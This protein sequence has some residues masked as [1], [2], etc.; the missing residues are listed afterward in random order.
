VPR[1]APRVALV[2]GQRLVPAQADGA[3]L[4]TGY[5]VTEDLSSAHLL[6]ARRADLRADLRTWRRAIPPD[7]RRTAAIA[8]ARLLRQYGLPRPHSRVG[9]Y[10]ALAEEFDTAPLIA[11]AHARQCTLYVPVITSYRQRR[12]Q[13][14]PLAHTPAAPTRGEMSRRRNRYGIEEP[15]TAERL[16]PRWLDLVIVPLVAFSAA[17]DRGGVR[18]GMGGGYYDRSFHFLRHRAS[19]Q[20]PRLLGLA[21]EQQ[22][23]THLEAAHWDVPLWGVLTE[24]RL[25]HGSPE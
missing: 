11:L 6:T 20:R 22:A 2:R 4:L 25:Y 15:L 8:A 21:Y 10:L 18:L 9:I 17:R 16:G 24:R 13:F 23:V 5:R 3:N 1:L 7:E 19:W 14:A 12:M